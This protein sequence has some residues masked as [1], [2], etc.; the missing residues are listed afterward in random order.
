MKLAQI[1]VALV[2]LVS[3][4]FVQAFDI[5]VVGLFRDMVIIRVDDNQYKLRVGEST[6]EGIKL[7]SANSEQAVLEIDGQRETFTLGSGPVQSSFAKPTKSQARIQPTRGMYLVQGFVNRQPVQFLL[8]TGAAWVAFNARQAKKLGINYRYEGTPGWASTANGRVR[9]YRLKLK[10]VRV[11]EIELR[12]VDAAVMDGDSP[13]TAL[14]GMTFL[15]RVTM[16][17][18]GDVLMLQAR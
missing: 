9:I 14:L 4:G 15:S 18:E 13:T 3:G 17:H 6:M 10:T 5:L 12:D 11:G 16:E 2:L 1:S 7:I 8:D